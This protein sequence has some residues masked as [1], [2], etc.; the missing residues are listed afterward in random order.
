MMAARAQPYKRFENKSKLKDLQTKDQSR[1]IS[2]ILKISLLWNFLIL[3]RSYF[4][5]LPLQFTDI[6]YL[7]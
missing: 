1:H 7:F 2:A 6:F 4:M 3:H 5:Y